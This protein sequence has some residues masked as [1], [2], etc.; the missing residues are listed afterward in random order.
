[1]KNSKKLFSLILFLG[2]FVLISCGERTKEEG[3]D[4]KTEVDPPEQIVSMDEAR[5]MYDNYTTRREPLIRKFEDSINTSRRDTSKFDVARYTFYDYDTIKQYLAY[6]EQEA[7][8]AGVEISSLRFYY[9]N[10]PDKEVFPDGSKVIHP[11]Q[12]SF[13]IIPT[14]KQDGENYAFT[15]EVGKDGQLQAV[16]LNGQLQ[17]YNPNEMGMNSRYTKKSYAGFT[18]GSALTT[19]PVLFENG[20]LTLNHGGAAPPPYQ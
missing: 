14:L 13:F 5:T 10:Y 20:S 19:P 12:N 17:P 6:I 3:T 8:K 7:A 11:R 2:T 9:S 15:T 16:L 18:A 4:S 1:M